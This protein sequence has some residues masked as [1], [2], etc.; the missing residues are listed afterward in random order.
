MTTSCKEYLWRRNTLM[1]C[2]SR[3]CLPS[4]ELVE[5]HDQ[6]KTGSSDIAHRLRVVV[7][8]YFFEET[9]FGE[10]TAGEVITDQ[11]IIGSWRHTEFGMD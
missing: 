11:R 9:S 5:G 4:C 7:G 6:D 1:Y 3:Q 10:E 2:C 8:P